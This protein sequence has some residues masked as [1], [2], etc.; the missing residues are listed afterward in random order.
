MRLPD[1]SPKYRTEE[2]VEKNRLPVSPELIKKDNFIKVLKKVKARG[3]SLLVKLRKFPSDRKL[4][5]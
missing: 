2:K 4:K 5:A 1:I 3:E